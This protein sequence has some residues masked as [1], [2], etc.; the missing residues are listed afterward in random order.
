M[1]D[2][3]DIDQNWKTMYLLQT[4]YQIN[5]FKVRQWWYFDKETESL[6]SMVRAIAP[7][8]FQEKKNGDVLKKPL[9]WI[10]MKQDDKK[11][12][13]YNDPHIIW[14]KET[15]STLSFKKVKRVKGRTKKTLKNLL[16][17]KSPAIARLLS[18][19]I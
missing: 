5:A 16:A 9:F 1:S 14:A 6:G 18:Y 12:Y 4:K 2:V 3:G 17:I 7:I 13:H 15:L 10:E 11:P 19:C 8:V